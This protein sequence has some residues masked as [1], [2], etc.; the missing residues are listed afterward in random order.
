MLA[1]ITVVKYIEAISDAEF[2]FY[3]SVSTGYKFDRDAII[4][5]AYVNGTNEIGVIIS[6]GTA[7][8]TT[9]CKIDGK[10]VTKRGGT[11]LHKFKFEAL[12]I[13]NLLHKI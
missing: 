11:L 13:G 12:N 6:S 8:T 10:R 9:P 7:S 5:Q 4:F 2:E 3:C 1:Q